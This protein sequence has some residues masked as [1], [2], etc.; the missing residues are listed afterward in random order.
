MPGALYAFRAF[1]VIGVCFGSIVGSPTEQEQIMSAIKQ[2]KQS[3]GA[4][5]DAMIVW[6]LAAIHALRDTSK[7]HGIHSRYTGIGA[8][9]R[10]Q[11]GE[12]LYTVQSDAQGKFTGI[13]GPLVSMSASGRIAYRS[14][15]GG[16]M[17]Y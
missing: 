16:F 5:L 17:L 12:A 9:F 10:E 2:S 4:A 8:A 6:L 7:S 1:V 15:K 13:V 11:F 14:V 3:S